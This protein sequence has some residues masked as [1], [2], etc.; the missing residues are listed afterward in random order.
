MTEHPEVQ[1]VRFTPARPKDQALG[2]LGWVSC[3]IDTLVRLDGLAVRR[4]LDG[5]IVIS[6]PARRTPSG[7]RYHYVRP[8][9]EDVRRV[10][11]D[12]ILA[13]IPHVQELP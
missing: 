3:T 1:N 12:Q 4:T 8:F 9:D 10:L 6:F 5:R 7:E 2:L 13:A 11:E